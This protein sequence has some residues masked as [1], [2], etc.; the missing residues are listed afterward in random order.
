M[1]IVNE[2]S[3]RKQYRGTGLEALKS[4]IAVGYA[5]DRGLLCYQYALGLAEYGEM[6]QAVGWAKSAL[7]GGG[8]GSHVWNLLALCLVCRGDGKKASMFC[9]TGYSECVASLVKKMG[10]DSPGVPFSWDLVESIDKEE[11]IK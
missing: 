2:P 4:A 6:D 9:E 10:A 1:Y 3:L 11:L 7:E 8:A 5:P